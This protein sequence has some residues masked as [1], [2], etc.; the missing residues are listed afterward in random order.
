MN[1]RSKEVRE[2]VLKLLNDY[3]KEAGDMEF[4]EF[5]DEIVCDVEA[6]VA[7]EEAK[8]LKVTDEEITG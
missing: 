4:L 7:C 3:G 8:P 6:I 5:L 2:K 1:A